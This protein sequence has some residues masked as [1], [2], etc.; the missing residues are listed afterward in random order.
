MTKTKTIFLSYIFFLLCLGTVHAQSGTVA[1]GGNASGPEG[2]TSYTIGTMCYT[3]ITDG[4]TVIT[5]GIQQPYEIFIV[6]GIEEKNIT[7]GSV[8]P[9]PTSDYVT[10]NINGDLQH[11]AYSLSDVHGTYISAKNL[12][13]QQTNIPLTS[14]ANGTYFIKVYNDKTQL[15]TYKIIKNN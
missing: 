3:T 6:N 8:Y 7:L 15:K 14:L 12:N 5:Q 1:S 2:T 10:L 13:K 9:N 4:S 11:M